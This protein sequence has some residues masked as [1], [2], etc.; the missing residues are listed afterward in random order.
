M[1]FEDVG[2]SERAYMV[3][4]IEDYEQIAL[5]TRGL[6]DLTEE[7][8]IDKIN[9]DIAIWKSQQEYHEDLGKKQDKTLSKTEFFSGKNF[10]EGEENR[11]SDDQSGEPPKRWTIPRDRKAAA[12]EVIE[13]DRQYFEEI[14][15]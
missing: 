3:M 11:A 7:E 8:L 9:R 4:D 6:T 14:T 1:V 12:E 10:W 5:N 13:E 2:D 15:F